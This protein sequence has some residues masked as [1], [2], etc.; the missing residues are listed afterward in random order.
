MEKIEVSYLRDGDKHIIETS[1]PTLGKIVID[2]EGVA[3]E[4]KLG[5]AKQ[6]LAAA[7]LQCYCAT[8]AQAMDARDFKYKSIKATANLFTGKNDQNL[9]KILNVDLDINV[10]I[11]EKD[12][13]AFERIQKIMR[14]GCIVTNSIHD[15]INMNYNLQAEF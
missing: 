2:H 9:N 8:L 1:N 15:G 4:L 7:S 12:K 5:I 11:D 10:E 3:P 14:S 13:E 6:F